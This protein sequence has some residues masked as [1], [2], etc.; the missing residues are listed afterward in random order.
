MLP[1]GNT[2]S[3]SFVKPLLDKKEKNTIIYNNDN[4]DN[5]NNDNNDNDDNDDNGNN[6]DNDNDN[7]DNN[8]ETMNHNNNN[9]NKELYNYFRICWNMFYSKK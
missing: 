8:N 2:A 4:N 5:G 1:R 3:Q 6:D 7:K 9:I